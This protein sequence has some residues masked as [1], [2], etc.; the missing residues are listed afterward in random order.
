MELYRNSD[1]HTIS[2]AMAF[3]V[4]R[5]VIVL[6]FFSFFPLPETSESGG[7]LEVSISS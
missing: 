2:K 4:R 7:F 3:P 1:D 5:V 6:V